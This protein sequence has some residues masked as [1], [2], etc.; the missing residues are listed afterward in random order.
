MDLKSYPRVY[1]VMLIMGF[2]FSMGIGLPRAFLPL[3]AFGLDPSGTMAG[4]VVSAWFFARIFVELPSG[5]ISSRLGSRNLVVGG[6][7]VGMIGSLV[8]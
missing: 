5:I 1:F 6:V 7:L 3:M 4:L 2:F 8:C